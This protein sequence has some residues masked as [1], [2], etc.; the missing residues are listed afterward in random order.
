M[1]TIFI[2]HPFSGDQEGNRSRVTRVARLLV[3]N[4]HLPL[5]PQI[6]LPA[7][8]DESTERDLALNMCCRLVAIS[9]EVRVFGEP[10]A[11]M[12]REISLAQRLGIPIVRGKIP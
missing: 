12:Q 4:G 11:G 5:A 7:F 9:D 10:T 3:L 1:S 6:Y 8:I 2:S